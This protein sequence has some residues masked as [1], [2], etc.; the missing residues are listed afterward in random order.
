MDNTGFSFQPSWQQLLNDEPAFLKHI[1]D[2]L[3]RSAADADLPVGPSI[4][5]VQASAVLFLLGCSCSPSGRATAEP[6]L[7]L[8]KRSAKV[9]QPGDLCC[10]GGSI[11]PR[12]DPLL[13]VL[14]R[15]PGSPLLRWEHWPALHRRQPLQSR[16]LALLF[17]TGLRES[18]E[19]MRLN[20]LGVKLLGPLQPENLVMFQRT[21]YP[22][23][24]W[25]SKQKRFFPNWEV[26]RIVSIPIREL[27][28][29]SRYVRFRLR[30]DVPAASARVNGTRNFACFLHHRRDGRTDRLWGATFRITM[31]FLDVVFGFHPP[32]LESLPTV[33]GKIDENYI[34]PNASVIGR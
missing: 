22:L 23:V 28:D 7:I 1:G 27:L 20:P 11:A 10:P 13:A 8:N 3:Q 17:A 32:P 9:R 5:S 15:L 34:N 19:E 21:I 31:E 33:E 2:A 12:L 18:A 16:K 25:V 24:C 26:E 30:I 14:L 6:C 4:R 29:P